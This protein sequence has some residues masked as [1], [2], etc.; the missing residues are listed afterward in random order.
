MAFGLAAVL[1]VVACSKDKQI[2]QP[3][4]LTPL[5]SP[6]LRVKHGWSASVG[7][8][9]EAA[10][11]LSLGASVADNR[12]YAAGHKGDVVGLELTSGHVV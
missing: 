3:A 7:D 12:V 11:R 10:L 9:K 5:P 6:S 2:D 4:K 8:S 1:F